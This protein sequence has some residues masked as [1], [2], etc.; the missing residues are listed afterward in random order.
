MP[1]G[2]ERRKGP[3]AWWD[4]AL[5][6][7][8]S[9]HCPSGVAPD[10]NSRSPHRYTHAAG[11]SRGALRGG[12]ELDPRAV[13]GRTKPGGAGRLLTGRERAPS[14]H[15]PVRRCARL[16]PIR[17]ELVRRG[18]NIGT[19][20]VGRGEG[21]RPCLGR[22]AP[23]RDEWPGAR[24][25]YCATRL[26]ASVL[27]LLLVL[28]CSRHQALI[29]PR[30]PPCHDAAGRDGHARLSRRRYARG[31][32]HGCGDGAHEWALQHGRGGL[33]GRRHAS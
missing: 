24:P 33:K 2:G 4:E 12:G 7:G 27:T 11:S 1:L 16:V 10:G 8:Q 5:W 23:V 29:W 32:G 30:L 31:S 3:R 18:A 9:L 17:P 6:R 19:G 22:P 28:R 21:L 25:S 26:G 15:P 20:S 13:H 14:W